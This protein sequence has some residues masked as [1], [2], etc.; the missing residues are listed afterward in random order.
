MPVLDRVASG[1]VAAVPPL[2][3]AVGMWFGWARLLEWKDT[4]R[5]CSQLCRNRHWRDRGLSSAA[6]AP[7]LQDRPPAPWRVR[8]AWLRG[9]G[10]S[11]DRLNRYSPQAPPALRRRRGC[12]DLPAPRCDVQHQLALS[13]L[14]RRDHETGDESRNLAWLAIP[15]WGEAW[16]DNRHALPTST[17]TGCAAARFDPSVGIIR[18]LEMAGARL[19][20][21]ARRSGAIAAPV[22]GR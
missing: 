7:Q 21:G 6:D 2:M 16:H 1:V 18:P 22:G 5:A 15:T 20:R 12:H 10:R 17:G 4:R 9:G 8:G 19:R 14:R 3:L 13:L 11:R